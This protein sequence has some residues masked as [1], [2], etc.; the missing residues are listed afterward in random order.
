[1]PV[2]AQPLLATIHKGSASMKRTVFNTPIIT[3]VFRLIAALCFKLTGWKVVGDTPAESKFMLIAAP[4]TSN[5]DFPIMLGATLLRRI[6]VS[7]LGKDS[8]FVGWRGPIARWLAGVPIDRSRSNDVVGQIVERYGQEEQFAVI[9]CPEGTRSKVGRWKTGFYHIARG[10][11]VPVI[12]GFAD[13][14]SKTT[15]FGPAFYP[16][17]DV[18]KDI[19]EI[20]DFYKD[21]RGKRQDLYHAG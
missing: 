4:H 3:P 11:Q 16:R 13:F 15:G 17:G 2:S 1:M 20:Q 7:W 10:A 14:P 19:R 12:L 18:E 8:L 9:I 5:W 6:Q 21:K